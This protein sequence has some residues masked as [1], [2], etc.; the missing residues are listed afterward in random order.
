MKGFFPYS[1]FD[2]IE[3]LNETYLPEHEEFYSILTKKSITTDEYQSC[4]E[5]WDREGMTTF[6]D[7]VKYYN[8]GDVVGFVEAVEKM[9]KNSQANKLDMFKDSV[10]LPGLTQRYMFNHLSKNDY[11]CGFSKQHKRSV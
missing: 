8:N 4:K 9:I 10:S 1:W 6:G 5:V 2:S 11:F 7:Y 3:K